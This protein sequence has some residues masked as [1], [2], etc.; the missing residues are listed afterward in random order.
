MS[1]IHLHTRRLAHASLGAA[2]LL[3]LF[4]SLTRAF[5]GPTPRL[6]PH[7]GHLPDAPPPP[8]LLPH[9]DTDGDGLLDGLEAQLARRYAPRYRFAGHQPG[10][11]G[12]PD[13]RDEDFFPLSV[14]RFE[15]QR[16]RG[17]YR[18]QQGLVRAEG[19]GWWEDD[20][21]HGYPQRLTGDPLG[22]APAYT[23]V[24]SEGA[25]L[26]I[27]YWLFYGF[28][29]ATPRVFGLSLDLGGHRGDWEHVA[30]EVV[31]EQV[32]AAVF[33]GHGRGWRV[34]REGLSLVEEHV[35]V[36]VSQGKHAAYPAPTV[37]PILDLPAWCVEVFDVA[38]GAGPTWDAWRGPLIDLG[39]R[40]AP[41]P[42]VEWIARTGR[43]G[44]DGWL[45]IGLS[46]TGPW[47]KPSWGDH[48]R[49]AAWPPD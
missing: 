14:E 46:P 39:E 30:V 11:L 32:R 34:E 35:E 17:L 25:S 37:R 28:D 19:P 22:Q 4:G 9:T 29:R 18:T 47:A 48:R 40:G 16:A 20:R 5:R 10:G 38:N 43:W 31:E 26:W 45:G 27:E 13:N 1:R 44:P 15:A 7:H 2:L 24:F 12:G 49:A 6:Q 21:L 41:R 23:H 33:Y 42:G 36:F 8:P 3:A